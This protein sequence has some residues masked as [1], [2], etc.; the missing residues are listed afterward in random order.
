MLKIKNDADL[1][2]FEKFGF[3]PYYDCETGKIA[4]WYKTIYDPNFTRK[5]YNEYT[6][7]ITDEYYFIKGNWLKKRKEV[8]RAIKFE[9]AE[10]GNFYQIFFDTLYDLIQA[11]IIER[12]VE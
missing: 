8:K 9:K 4:Y 7:K 1:K 3:K 6:I 2:E 12:V 5:K 11:G 10:E